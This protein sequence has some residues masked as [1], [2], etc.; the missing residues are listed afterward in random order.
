M[1]PPKMT[2]EE[3]KLLNVV[4]NFESVEK[5]SEFFG[6]TKKTIYNNIFKLHTGRMKYYQ[7]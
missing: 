2:E 3:I 6:R 5:L 7:D 1:K 4:K